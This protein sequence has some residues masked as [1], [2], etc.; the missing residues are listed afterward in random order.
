MALSVSTVQLSCPRLAALPMHPGGGGSSTFVH[1]TQHFLQ[2]R[3][4]TGHLRLNL[5]LGWVSF[6][7]CFSVLPFSGQPSDR[8]FHEPPSHW[9]LRKTN[10]WTLIYSNDCKNTTASTQNKREVSRKRGERGPLQLS[11]REQPR[12]TS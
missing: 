6:C 4:R 9:S 7:F 1:R 3:D 10:P 12:T 5:E 2:L 11:S 8:S